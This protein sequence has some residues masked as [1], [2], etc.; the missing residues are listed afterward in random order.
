MLDGCSSHFTVN[1]IQKC[2][3][4]NVKIF[5]LPPHETQPLDLLIFHLHKNEI[6]KICE[7]LD[8]EI[9]SQRIFDFYSTF[10]S[11]ATT[12]NIKKSFERSGAV[13]DK[14]DSLY[15]IIH[16]SKSYATNLTCDPKSKQQVKEIREKRE[17]SKEKRIKVSE[18][19]ECSP[20]KTSPKLEKIIQSL[21]NIVENKLDSLFNRILAANVPIEYEKND[22]EIEQKRAS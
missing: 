6:M 1:L 20:T 5:F 18:L 16:Y 7:D 3:A 2:D 10:Q 17:G 21:P 13:Y 11:I 9:I 14:S 4:N 19:N 22:I 8:D 15:P 12:K